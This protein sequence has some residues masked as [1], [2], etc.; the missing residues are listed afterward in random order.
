MTWGCKATDFE[1]TASQVTG[2]L[3]SRFQGLRH[4]RPAHFNMLSGYILGS[5][6]DLYIHTDIIYI[7]MCV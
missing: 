5:S 6:S 7:Y 2:C 3:L 4:L 1:G